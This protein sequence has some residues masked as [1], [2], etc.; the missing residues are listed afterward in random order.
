[1]ANIMTKTIVLGRIHYH[2]CFPCFLVIHVILLPSSCILTEI[3]KD[4]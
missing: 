4:L 1:M 3:Y 2:Q